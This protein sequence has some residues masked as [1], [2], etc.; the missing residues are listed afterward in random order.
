MTWMRLKELAEQR[1]LEA[2]PS[3]LYGD[4]LACDA[5][6]AT[7]RVARVFAPALIVFGSEDKMV[8]PGAGRVL[9]S[10]LLQG[11]IEVVPGAGH[12]VMLEQP[13]R[14]AA[15]LSEFLGSLPYQPGK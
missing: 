8:P 3:V 15:L 14:V 5:F 12:M 1:M 13:E 6:D 2:R 9:A 4:F 10:Q 7:G 11:R